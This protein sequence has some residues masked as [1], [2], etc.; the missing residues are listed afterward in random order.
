MDYDLEAHQSKSLDEIPAIE[1]EYAITMGCGD[2][3]PLV[4]AKQRDDWAI[5]DP[6]HMN[7]SDFNQI[8]DQIEQQGIQQLDSFK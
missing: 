2:E 5:P 3:C 1:Y 6:K 8:R 4:R 7:P